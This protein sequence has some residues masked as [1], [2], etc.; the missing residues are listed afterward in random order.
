MSTNKTP[1]P[2]QEF[3][4]LVQSASF[5]FLLYYRGH[6]CPFCIAHF[7]QLIAISD[8]IKAAGGVI[9]AATAEVPEHLDKFRAST[10]FSD[11]VIVDPENELAK[12]LKKKELLDVAITDS[13]L[14][15][16]RGYKHGLAQPALL[17]MK[18][19]GTL[20]SREMNIG[21]ATDRPVLAEVWR[22][23]QKQLRGED[24]RATITMILA[25]STR[26]SAMV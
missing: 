23:V 5:V 13:Q 9:A 6:W 19:D 16:L 7:K 20:T 3:D 15:Q 21:G 11:T 10:G 26:G 17:V 2:V 14:Y 12:H 24:T 8:E 22:N 1:G 4:H 18:R 25:I